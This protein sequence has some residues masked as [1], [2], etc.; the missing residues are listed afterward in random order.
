VQRLARLLRQDED[1]TMRELERRGIAAQ[2][3]EDESSS[4]R[5]SN[6]SSETSPG[7]CRGPMT[8]TSSTTAKCRPC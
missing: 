8:T 2:G 7:R 1:V 6:K 5:P 4:L 3:P